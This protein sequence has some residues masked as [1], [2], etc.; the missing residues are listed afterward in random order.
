LPALTDNW[1]R[2]A[3]SRH[4]T[5]PI[6]RTRPSPRRLRQVNYY[7]FPIPLSYYRY[8]H[9]TSAAQVRTSR[10]KMQELK[11]TDQL[12]RH[13]NGPYKFEGPFKNT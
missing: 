2:G 5:A 13:E 3:A 9:K 1:T 8:V 7:S 12:S 4:T 10:R 11:T 6:S